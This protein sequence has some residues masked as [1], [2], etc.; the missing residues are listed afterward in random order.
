M[1]TTSGRRWLVTHNP[2]ARLGDRSRS[3]VFMSTTMLIHNSPM[4]KK[5]LLTGDQIILY[6]D[7]LFLRCVSRLSQQRLMLS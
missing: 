5:R 3:W 7:S 6:P 1:L 2:D 4:I